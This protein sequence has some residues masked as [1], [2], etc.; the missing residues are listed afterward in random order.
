[1]RL[2]S[3]PSVAGWDWG[4]TWLSTNS[5]R[6]RFE[7]VNYLLGSDASKLEV[8]EESQRPASGAAALRQARKKTGNPWTSNRTGGALKAFA[9]A[10]VSGSKDYDKQERLDMRQRVLRHFLLSGPDVHVH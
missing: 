2:F 1:M 8:K 7:A 6:T 3:P 10:S 9:K 4:P 5:M